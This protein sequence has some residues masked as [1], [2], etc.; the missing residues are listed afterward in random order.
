[1]QIENE[2]EEEEN[3]SFSSNFSFSMINEMMKTRAT[4]EKLE[5]TH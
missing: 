1:M 4:N 5:E 2:E 3:D